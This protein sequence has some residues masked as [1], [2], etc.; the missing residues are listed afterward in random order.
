MLLMCH[1]IAMPLDMSCGY[2]RNARAGLRIDL[3]GPSPGSI[4]PEAHRG[5]DSK[6]ELFLAL[7]DRHL[8]AEMYN[9]ASQVMSG[10][11]LEQ[12]VEANPRRSFADQLEE[13]RTWNV[14]TLEFILYALRH[15]WA[16]QQ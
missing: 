15:P 3:L 5:F 11:S 10:G 6:E 16:Q 12:P 14:L 8:A 9:M 13:N 1:E 2:V 4:S 7:L